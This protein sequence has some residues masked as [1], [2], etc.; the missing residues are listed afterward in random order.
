[1]TGG[2]EGQQQVNE[3]DI[4]HLSLPLVPAAGQPVG[5]GGQEPAQH[6]THPAP[7]TLLTPL[8]PLTPMLAWHPR[9]ATALAPQARHGVGVATGL[10][11][12]EGETWAGLQHDTRTLIF[13]SFSILS[14]KCL[15]AQLGGILRRQLIFYFVYSRECFLAKLDRTLRC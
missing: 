6:A 8:H 3:A 13:K 10:G 5:Q 2:D 14:R 9:R 15:S 4:T 11:V 1:M 7:P 12:V